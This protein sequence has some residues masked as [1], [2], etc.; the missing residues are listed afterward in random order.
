MSLF[1]SIRLA[2][3]TLR[4]DQIAM[5][6][7]GQNIANAS[8]EGYIREEVVLSPGPTQR[9]GTLLLGTG[10]RVLAVVQ[11]I[12]NFLEERLRGAVSERAGLETQEDTCIQLE[13]L[14]GELGDTDLS[15]SLSDFFGAISEVLNQP[16]SVSTRNLVVLQGE[17]LTTNVNNLASRVQT[18]RND[19]DERVEMM[20]DDINRLVENI[21]TL[22]VRIAETEGGGVSTSDAVGLR[23]QRLV[24][25]SKLSELINIRTQEQSNGT[26]SVYCGGEFLVYEGISREVAVATHTDRGMTVADIRLQETD[27]P[28]DA[29]GGEYYGLLEARYTVLGGFLDALDEFACTLAFE[30]NKI[31][32]SGQGLSGYHELTSEVAVDA[33]DQPLDEVGLDVAPV[34][35]SFQVLV[36]NAKT[37]LTQT[38]DVLVDLN[39]LGEDT[40]LDDLVAA[41][42]AIDGISA[43]ATPSN[44]LSLKSDSSDLEFAFASDTSGV[45]A[46]LGLNTFFTGSSAL[47]L[48]VSEVLQRDPGKFA[49]SRGGI[50]ADTDNAIDLAAFLDAPIESQNGDSLS[51]LYDRMVADVAQGSAVTQALAEGARV[52][53]QTLEGQ[54]LATSGVSV[55]EETINLLGYQQS[56]QASA[57]YISVLSKLFEVLVNI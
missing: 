23:D 42:D 37:G 11:K 45:L 6:V 19:L 4:A 33:T 44:G 34:N 54:K 30:F 20:A 17:T 43:T 3:N 8:T 1:S 26:V 56:Y 12:D 28:L 49:A 10:V 47:S 27:S 9:L 53:E 36:H 21:R 39:G 29:G 50:A 15:T 32:S 48:G 5:Q 46:A 57:R 55:D 7:I 52:F 31:Y 22:N 13:Q 40:T 51:G 16:E 2:A 38:T 41:M 14:I 18:I 25:L 24:A 35:G